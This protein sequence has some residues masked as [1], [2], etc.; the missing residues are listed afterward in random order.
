MASALTIGS[1]G[2]GGREGPTAQISAG[3]GSILARRINLSPRDSRLAVAAGIGSGIGAIFRTPLGGAVLGAEILYRDDIEA[4]AL[5]PSVIASVTG[6]GVYG[7]ITGNFGPIF[8][9]NSGAVLARPGQVAMIALVGAACG[10]LGRLYIATFYGLTRLFRRAPAPRMLRPALAGLAV[11]ALGL[12]VP[13]V[14]GTGYGVL[15]QTLDRAD[16]L[17]MTLW[18]VLALPVV[19]ILA[20][21]L[22]IGSGGSAGVFGR[23][24]WSAAPRARASGGCSSW[25]EWPRTARRRS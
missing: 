6:Y 14:L 17:D 15:Q 2:S 1:G 12:L 16:L 23:A 24:W 13:G 5:I 25:P 11:G 18:A 22:T 20:T 3:F 21:S 19:K 9:Y 7:A 10:L 8:G 4:D